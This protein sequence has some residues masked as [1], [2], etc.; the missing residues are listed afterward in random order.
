MKSKEKR[1]GFRYVCEA[2]KRR[3]QSRSNNGRYMLE[4]ERKKEWV[5]PL[6]IE[7]LEDRR[8]RFAVAQNPLSNP[9]C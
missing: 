9:A 1:F 4:E 5:T 3:S 2:K 7:K 6:R 8:A